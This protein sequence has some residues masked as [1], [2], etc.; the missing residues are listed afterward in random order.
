MKQNYKRIRLEFNEGRNDPSR[1]T[2]RENV[3]KLPGQHYPIEGQ[4]G[5]NKHYYE[6]DVNGKNTLKFRRDVSVREEC[7]FT[8]EEV[9]EYVQSFLDKTL[10]L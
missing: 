9:R 7:T 5:Y 8:E 4:L 2:W 3:S 10:E 1:H 6:I